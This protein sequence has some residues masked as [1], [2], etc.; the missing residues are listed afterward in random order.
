MR[1]SVA[2]HLWMPMLLAV[3]GRAASQG[4]PSSPG[5]PWTPPGDLLREQKTLSAGPRT[6]VDPAHLYTLPELV[7]LA[8]QHNPATRA[9]WELAK[10]RA[11]QLR[12]AQSD[13]LPTLSA[14][15]LVGTSR[16]GVLFGST[17]VRQTLG[18]YEP[19]LRVNYLLLDFGAR[20]G[21]IAAA[22]EQLAAADF[23]FNS[24]VLTVL[25]GT[26]QRYY[27][28]LNAEGQRAAAEVN[29]KNAETVRD[30]VN[31]RL[32]VGLATLPDALEARAAAAQAQY[33]LQAAIGQVDLARGD[34]LDVLGASP[35]SPLK[36]QPLEELHLPETMDVSV[37]EATELGLAQRPE[38][39]E[40]VAEKNAAA[41]SIRQARSTF[42]PTVTFSGYGGEIRAYGQQDQLPGL[43]AGPVEVWDTRLELRWDLFEGGRR[44]A[45][46]AQA[47]AEERR[48]QA[49][50]DRTRDEIEDQVWGAFV[51]LRTAFQERDAAAALL[52]AARSSYDA[53]LRSY[54]LGVRNTVDVV[55][56][57]RSL[58]QALSA[59]VTARTDVLTQL[60]NFSYRT[61][62]LLQRT[63]SARRTP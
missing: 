5:A 11:N 51:R 32:A 61:G 38:L 31:A 55:T 58:A 39:G 17:F 42:L 44:R 29:L 33:T 37:Q 53:A 41:A 45:E 22:R 1:L 34:L 9:S 63:P 6:A 46:L 47:H 48:A 50:I 25:Y 60:A 28:L 12:V 26:E 36:V 14:A 24:T 16:Q 2:T 59:D 15:A 56:A 10:V 43:Y 52:V 20:A 27:S 54:Q 13:L 35:M 18:Y 62:D 19:V 57:Q 23:A 4:I 8:E 3:A 30:A 21:R 49:E 7:D 40:R